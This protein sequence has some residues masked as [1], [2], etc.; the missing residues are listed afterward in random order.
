M[1]PCDHYIKLLSQPPQRCFNPAKQACTLATG[2][3]AGYTTEYERRFQPSEAGMYPCDSVV[4]GELPGDLQEVS[5]QRSRHVPL[6]PYFATKYAPLLISFN[7]AKQACTLATLRD[8]PAQTPVIWM[9]QPSEAGMYPCDHIQAPSISR[10]KG[11][12]PSEAGM[13]PCD[14]WT[15]LSWHGPHNV[16][17][18]RSRH[19]PLRLCQRGRNSKSHWVST[20]RS[21]HVPLRHLPYEK[22]VTL[23]RSFN[24]AKQ[25]CT[26]ATCRNSAHFSQQQTWFQPSEAGMY[27]CD[28]LRV[29]K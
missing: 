5:T 15:A 7:P 22:H 6:R 9:F 24:P 8:L 29:V 26:L 16:S 1:Y 14:V 2:F 25:A 27:P 28:M 4:R 19:V 20:Q 17:T 18:Q 10:P 12:Q 21:R 11:F 13:Y 3:S 23:Q